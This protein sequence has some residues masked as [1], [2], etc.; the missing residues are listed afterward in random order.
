MSALITGIHHVSMKCCSLAEFSRTVDFYHR[1]LGLPVLRRW[2]SDEQPAVML[3]CGSGVIEIFADA[4]EELPQGCIRHFALATPDVD[5]CAKA[6]QA[7]GYE[8]T[9]LPKDI[10]IE[11]QPVFSARIAFCIGPLG[12]EIE[13]FQEK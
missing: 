10:E 8:I 1:T 5:A 3:E 9:V 6:V 2:G 12:E 4:T 7:A 13:F 11:S